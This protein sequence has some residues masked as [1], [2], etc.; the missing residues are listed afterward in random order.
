MVVRGDQALR[1]MAAPVKEIEKRLRRLVK[2]MDELLVRLYK[3]QDLGRF[4][5]ATV[6]E[7]RVEVPLEGK[8]KKGEVTLQDRLMA[9][10]CGE[11]VFTKYCWLQKIFRRI[12]GLSTYNLVPQGPGGPGGPLLEDLQALQEVRRQAR[13]QG[14]H[15]EGGQQE[16]LTC[17][18]CRGGC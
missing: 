1:K 7:Y 13:P 2:V 14:D 15:G 12:E 18:F 4:L 17:P 16:D 9:L 10:R 3:Q 11:A 8:E 6:D 5:V